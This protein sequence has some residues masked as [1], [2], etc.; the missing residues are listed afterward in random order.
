M[1]VC[2]M[3]YGSNEGEHLPLPGC[4]RNFLEVKTHEQT[5]ISQVVRGSKDIPQRE[6][7]NIKKDSEI[8]N[9]VKTSS[10]L[11]HDFLREST[12]LQ[13]LEYKVGM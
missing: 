8:W 3:C 9:T 4:L 10:T 12:T 6:L 7:M 1:K 13:L 11:V 5:G 2:M